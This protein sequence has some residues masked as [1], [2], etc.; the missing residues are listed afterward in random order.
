MHRILQS[1]LL[2]LC[3]PKQKLYNHA[4][5]VLHSPLARSLLIS[6]LLSV[7][8]RSLFQVLHILVFP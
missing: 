1:S 3:H 4:V 2:S 8:G 7:L 5:T 6:K